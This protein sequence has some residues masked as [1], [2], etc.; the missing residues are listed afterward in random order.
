MHWISCVQNRP[1]EQHCR[2]D[3]EIIDGLVHLFEE[4]GSGRASRGKEKGKQH[5]GCQTLSNHTVFESY[6]YLIKPVPVT[7]ISILEFR[8]RKLNGT[9]FFTADKRAS[10][11]IIWEWLSAFTGTYSGVS[12]ATSQFQWQKYKLENEQEDLKIDR[13]HT[14]C[15]R[16]QTCDFFSPDSLYLNIQISHLYCFVFL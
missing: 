16:I 9:Q 14:D 6:C 1:A 10:N 3:D 5:L 12:S 2:Q 15:Y 8:S 4:Y 7:S 11:L 13:G